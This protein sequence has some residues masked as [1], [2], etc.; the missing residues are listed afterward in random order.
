[1]F[2]NVV[3][4]VRSSEIAVKAKFE[5]EI[6]ER[7]KCNLLFFQGPQAPRGKSTPIV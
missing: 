3:Y 5:E 1:M 2:F 7:L 6:K 4:Q